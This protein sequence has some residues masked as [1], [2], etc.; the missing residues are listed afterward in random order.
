MY[1]L[2]KMTS[3][4]PRLAYREALRPYNKVMLIFSPVSVALV[5]VVINC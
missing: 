5:A 1:V 3:D 4:F 2:R